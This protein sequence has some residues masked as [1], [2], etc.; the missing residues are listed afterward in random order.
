MMR[1]VSEYR[2][3]KVL[4]NFLATNKIR[5]SVVLPANICLDVVDTLRALDLNLIFVD[6]SSKTLC[7]DEEQ[8]MRYVSTAS[9]LFFVHTYGIELDT[10]KFFKKVKQC[11]PNIIIVD[12]KCLCLPQFEI[13]EDNADLVLYSFGPK[14]QVNLGGGGFGFV[15]DKWEYKDCNDDSGLLLNTKWILN[16][17][18]VLE[19]MQKVV[20]HKKCLNAIYRANL[21]DV[22]QMPDAFQH[23][24][25]N[26][27][28]DEKD[29]LLQRIFE[30]GLFASNHYVPMDKSCVV[31]NKLHSQVINLFNDFYYTVEQALAT[32]EILN[33]H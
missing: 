33:N 8:S 19:Q 7:L 5:G 23:W 1:L 18:E 17:Y 13:D 25:F 29:E 10:I 27:K 15:M 4:F 32:C 28:V 26:I 30:R 3:N 12:D 2:A 21:P 9:V 6:I 24:R 31:A 14:K 22:W 20:E 11:N 16:K